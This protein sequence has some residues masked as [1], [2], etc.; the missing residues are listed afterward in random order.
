[1]MNK[2]L[3][4]FKKYISSGFSNH[5]FKLVTELEKEQLETISYPVLVLHAL[6]YD[7]NEIHGQLNQHISTYGVSHEIGINNYDKALSVIGV[8]PESNYNIIYDNGAKATMPIKNPYVMRVLECPSVLF[9]GKDNNSHKYERI[10][11][12]CGNNK[13]EYYTI[14]PGRSL[15]SRDFDTEMYREYLTI[16]MSSGMMIPYLNVENK[17]NTVKSMDFYRDGGMYFHSI[18]NSMQVYQ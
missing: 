16:N 3:E 4:L 5:L 14:A 8:K 1:M 7:Q 11:F 6:F 10:F 17:T 9:K 15:Y 13:S 18:V 12:K 2:T